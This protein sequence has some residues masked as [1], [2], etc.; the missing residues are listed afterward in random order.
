MK[1]LIFA[2]MAVLVQAGHEEEKKETPSR[3]SK[4]DGPPRGD[5]DWVFQANERDMAKCY[6]SVRY[7]DP[8]SNQWSK[9]LMMQG[10]YK[11]SNEY[12]GDPAPGMSK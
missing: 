5:D 1:G 12:F 9:D 7:G 11:C 4:L 3:D 8:K 6:G 2:T 10:E